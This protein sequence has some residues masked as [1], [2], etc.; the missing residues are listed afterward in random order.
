MTRGLRFFSGWSRRC[1]AAATNL[2]AVLLPIP[3]PIGGPKCP[4]CRPKGVCCASRLPRLA[5][6][7][8][9]G[10]ARVIYPGSARLRASASH[11]PP[12]T[13]QFSV[14]SVDNFCPGWLGAWWRRR[15]SC[16]KRAQRVRYPGSAS[17]LP[18]YL[19]RS[20]FLAVRV[21]YPGSRLARVVYPGNRV[22]AC[23]RWS[24]VGRAG[25]AFAGASGRH[26]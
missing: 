20:G 23:F 3:K 10:S 2:Y 1:D 16:Q 8:Y 11:L 21:T 4:N 13:T 19:A 7:G 14:E 18:R 25:A 17:R 15:G 12:F 6:V 9:P 24:G 26:R 5:R 22:A